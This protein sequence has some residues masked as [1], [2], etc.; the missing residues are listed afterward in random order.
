MFKLGKEGKHLSF[1]VR[2][3]GFVRAWLP[4]LNLDRSIDKVSFL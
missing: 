4:E 2:I 1:S 3:R